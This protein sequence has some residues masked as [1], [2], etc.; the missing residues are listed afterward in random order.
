MKMYAGTDLKDLRRHFRYR[1]ERIGIERH[2]PLLAVMQGGDYL[3]HAFAPRI[4]PFRSLFMVAGYCL[5]NLFYGY[6]KPSR[7]TASALRLRLLHFVYGFC[8]S[9]TVAA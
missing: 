3:P 7:F 5:W 4:S 8:I 9:D 6:R 2:S 1:C